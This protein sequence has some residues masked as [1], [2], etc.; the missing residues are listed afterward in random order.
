MKTSKTDFLLNRDAR[1]GFLGDKHFAMEHQ[2]NPPPIE[3][4]APDFS[5]LTFVKDLHKRIEKNLQESQEAEFTTL[6]S[7]STSSPPL[8]HQFFPTERGQV[9]NIFDNNTSYIKFG[10]N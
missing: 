9:S 5:T 10:L 6:S 7:L 2:E 8:S 1:S 4:M 3:N